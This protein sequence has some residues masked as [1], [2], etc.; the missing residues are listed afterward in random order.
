M[1]MNYHKDHSFGLHNSLGGSARTRVQI[2]PTTSGVFRLSRGFSS[3]QSN[4][5]SKICAMCSN[6][7]ASRVHGKHSKFLFTIYNNLSA[8]RTFF[9]M[10]K[11]SMIM[12][13]IMWHVIV[14][15]HIN[16]SKQLTVVK[17]FWQSIKFEMKHTSASKQVNG[18]IVI[19]L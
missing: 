9:Y 8:H 16:I 4:P 11:H 10:N 18:C 13:Y 14:H 6:K 15:C 7:L 5:N 19:V 17:T 2:P 3:Q 12:W 1:S